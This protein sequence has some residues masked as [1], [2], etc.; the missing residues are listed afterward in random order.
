MLPRSWSRGSGS[1]CK[2]ELWTYTPANG[3]AIVARDAP[4]VDGKKTGRRLVPGETFMVTQTKKVGEVTFLRL[5]GGEGWLF[6][7]KPG[8]GLVATKGPPPEAQ[9]PGTEGAAGGDAAPAPLE[10]WAVCAPPPPPV[11]PWAAK[12]EEPLDRED[13][14]MPDV[15]RSDDDFPREF[16]FVAAHDL[17]G[18]A[19]DWNGPMFFSEDGTFRREDGWFGTGDK[20]SWEAT[21]STHLTLRWEGFDAEVV[22]SDDQGRSFKN[23]SGFALTMKEGEPPGWF[24]DKFH[25]PRTEEHHGTFLQLCL[26]CCPASVTEHDEMQVPVHKAW[27]YIENAVTKFDEGI[28]AIEGQM[29][30]VLAHV[31]HGVDSMRDAVVDSLG[32]DEKFKSVSDNTL[33]E[34]APKA[35]DMVIEDAVHFIPSFRRLDNATPQDLQGASKAACSDTILSFRAKIHDFCDDVV[36][37]LKEGADMLASALRCLYKVA[38]WILRACRE[39][40]QMAVDLLKKV[41]PDCC[42]AACLS[43]AGLG[44]K[45]IKWVTTVFN[46]IVDVVEDLIQRALRTFGVPDWICE[47]VDFNGNAN[48]DNATDDDEPMKAKREKRLQATQGEYAPAQQAMDGADD[49]VV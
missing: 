47:K 23:E 30:D 9:D 11:E 27:G 40:V 45:L 25:T 17:E 8:V 29:V 5:A 43:C 49:V 1:G 12:A 13:T 48:A 32:L 28:D 42:E 4:K 14:R 7:T 44:A 31:S 15:E 21:S 38:S 46:K 24:L 34:V 16:Q 39:G 20:G 33:D 41:I 10:P 3:K 22:T 37:A 35:G 36:E 19:Q 2:D 26:A 6:D 18:R